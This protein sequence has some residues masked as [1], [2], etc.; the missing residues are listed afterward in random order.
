M[1]LYKIWYF[2]GMVQTKKLHMKRSHGFYFNKLD[3]LANEDYINGK[4]K[5][6]VQ[7]V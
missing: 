3:T 7:G 6:C 4:A 2:L 1:N 5:K